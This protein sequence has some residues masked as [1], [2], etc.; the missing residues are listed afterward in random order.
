MRTRSDSTVLF[1]AGMWFQ[2]LWT[3][4]FRYRDAS[5]PTRPRAKS[6]SAPTTQASAAIVFSRCT[7]PRRRRGKHGKRRLPSPRKPV[8]PPARATKAA[9][10]NENF[11]V[12]VDFKKAPQPAGA[13]GSVLRPSHSAAGA[14]AKT[15]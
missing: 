1:I 13:L 11:L 6:R 2:D 5:S 10:A 3:Y 12:P 14:S 15:A 9:I 8:P 4:D 7:R